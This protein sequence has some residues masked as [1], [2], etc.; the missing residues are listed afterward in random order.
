MNTGS[1]ITRSATLLAGVKVWTKHP[2][3]GIGFT[4][5]EDIVSSLTEVNSLSS[6]GFTTFLAFGG[7]YM[8]MLYFG[9]FFAAFSSS[10]LKNQKKKLVIATILLGIEW[11]ISSVYL[12]S[13][14]IFIICIGYATL[15]TDHGI[16]IHKTE[17]SLATILEGE[18]IQEPVIHR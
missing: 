1:G 5:T 12:Q 13:A 3:L 2:L 7:L 15:A 17:A 10:L 9:S 6:M 14:F 4:D 8:T 18:E 11:C 16:S